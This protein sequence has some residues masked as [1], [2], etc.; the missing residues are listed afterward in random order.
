VAKRKGYDNAVLL[1]LSAERVDIQGVLKANKNRFR[2]HYTNS[3][4][5]LLLKKIGSVCW[6]FYINK[7]DKLSFSSNKF[8]FQP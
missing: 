8:S 5:F 7:I 1:K 3:N 4:E 6:R 2:V